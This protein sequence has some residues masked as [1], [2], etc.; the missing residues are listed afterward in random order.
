MR[1]KYLI[2]LLFLL[3]ISIF[4]MELKGSEKL[5]AKNG[6]LDLS[7]WNFE[8]K[9]IT[10][11]NGEW[12]FHWNK[13]ISP[14][15][16]ETNI[17]NIYTV[18]PGVWNNINEKTDGHGVATYRIKVFL[19]DFNKNY[20][21]HTGSIG[22]AFKLFIDGKEYLSSGKVGISKR[23]MKGKLSS[24]IVTFKP[25]NNE[26]E[27]TVQV[28]NFYDKS[29]G[30]WDPIYIGL[31]NQIYNLK[32]RKIISDM[33]IFGSILIMGIYHLMLF[34]IGKREKYILYFSLFS[35]TVA[36]R[37]IIVGE[38]LINDI[39]KN[40]SFEF[41]YK[42]EFITFF[43]AAPLI[44]KFLHYLFEDEFPKKIIE[45]MIYIG[46]IFVGVVIIFPANIYSHTGFLYQIYMMIF[47]I[48]TIVK[49]SF[50]I[51]KKKRGALSFLIGVSVLVLA[52]INDVLYSNQIIFTG[53]YT[54]YGF[55]ILIISQ[56]IVISINMT[57]DYF[58]ILELEDRYRNLV[59]NVGDGVFIIKQS[60][61]IFIN[62]SMK[63]I[64]GYEDENLLI[65]KI[66]ECIEDNFKNNIINGYLDTS[67]DYE[68]EFCNQKN[69][70]IP[71]IINFSR[72][73]LNGEEVLIGTLK[74][75]SERKKI[76][77]IE[78]E[79]KEKLEKDVLEKTKHL[80]ENEKNLQNL[81][82][83]A[84]Q[85]LLLISPITKEIIRVNRS[86]LDFINMTEDE[87]IGYSIE[88][89]IM[90]KNLDAFCN[91]NCKD[92]EERLDKIEIEF[93]NKGKIDTM[94]MSASKVYFE[95][96][97]LNLIALTNI[98]KQ[99][100]NEKILNRFATIDEMTGLVNRRTGLTVLE[101][102]FENAKRH[103]YDLTL[104]FIDVDGL[105]TVNDTYGHNDGDWLIKTISKVVLDNIRKGDTAFR[106]G[107]DEIVLILINCAKEKGKIIINRINS[108]LHEINKKE[109]KPYK[110]E[111]SSGLTEMKNENYKDYKE[112]INTA[113]EIMY[114][115][116]VAKKN[117]F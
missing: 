33:F 37:A 24:K 94:L 44:A 92:L 32:K 80:Q 68:V 1:F 67:K 31:E 57:L 100:N 55:L 20:A 43:M 101:K 86:A 26:V 76:E 35:L 7:N 10:K 51:K 12:E 17:N 11:L 42:L 75:I 22:T 79:Y 116:K 28:S 61:I 99:K 52:L 66:D 82:D 13:L 115:N 49:I 58:K 95:K 71:V 48:Y 15:E 34:L 85:I 81:F 41:L 3:S 69:N 45:K 108:D 106:Y 98:T 112:F 111:I 47:A 59:D 27:I 54:S 21:L 56:S 117:K 84:P 73:L 62:E 4:S 63:K 113:D 77:R 96:M 46:L 29:G 14:K 64:L 38:R 114:K 8:K 2:I 91:S 5:T 50:A 53:Y 104:C 93:N 25:A 19:K 18:V 30:F 89:F 107:G 78:K 6:I 60:N 74:D 102:E 105:K 70:K 23:K 72:T 110:L 87:L 40:L 90:S 65:N 88:N 103:N 83:N 39:F 36:L 9:G 97:E 109:N 16:I